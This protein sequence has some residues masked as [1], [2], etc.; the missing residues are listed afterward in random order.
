MTTAQF[1]YEIEAMLEDAGTAV[2]ATVDSEGRPGMRWMTP[3]ILKD[4]PNSIYAVT[5]LDF[6]KKAQLEERPEVQWMFQTRSLNRIAHVN[7]TAGLLDNPA[8]RAEVLEKIGGKL[9]VFWKLKADAGRLVVIETV[10][11]EGRFF[12]PMKGEVKTVV[13]G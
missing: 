6:R 13:F 7:G 11:E 1:M 5:S 12:L 10:I 4:R 2:L 3:A 9:G 8:M